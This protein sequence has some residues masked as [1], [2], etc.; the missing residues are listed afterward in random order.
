MSG[1]LPVCLPTPSHPCRQL[2][3]LLLVKTTEQAGSR[4]VFPGRPAAKPAHCRCPV[5][6][7]LLRSTP[8]ECRVQMKG[9]LCG[10]QNPPGDYLRDLQRERVGP[11]ALLTHLEQPEVTLHWLQKLTPSRGTAS[12]P[13]TVVSVSFLRASRRLVLHSCLVSGP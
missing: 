4:A 9:L 10:T 12:Q 2:A 7:C 6:S 8:S 5:T 1:N 11:A 13:H 3:F